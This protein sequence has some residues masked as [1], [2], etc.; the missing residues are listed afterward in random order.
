MSRQMTTVCKENL[1]T[2]E[3]TLPECQVSLIDYS[4]F[5][6]NIIVTQLKGQ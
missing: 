5:A 3:D 4:L 2:E 1:A 6:D